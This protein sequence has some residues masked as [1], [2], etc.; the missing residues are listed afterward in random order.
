MVLSKDELIGRLQNEIRIL[1]H[2]V[3]KVD[4]AALA[5][6]PTPGQRSLLEL[7]RY[8]TIFAGIH[9]RTIVAGVWTMDAWREEWQTEEG[10]AERRGLEAIT[11]ELAR[12]PTMVAEL[13][14]SMTEADLRAEMTLFG[15]TAS[16]GS[17]LV[18]LVLCHYSAYRMQVFL[19]LKACGHSDLDTVDLWAGVDSMPR[20]T[21]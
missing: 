20:P 8:L 7:L 21:S 6:R 11:A 9:L 17:W 13:I 1:L 16:R 18:W 5:Y 19:Y 10:R 12:Q 15:S 14:G 2:L 4:A 3:S